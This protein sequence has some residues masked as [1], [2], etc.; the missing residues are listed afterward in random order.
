MYLICSYDAAELLFQQITSINAYVN[1]ESSTGGHP[2][3]Y[4]G[5]P[6]NQWEHDRLQLFGLGAMR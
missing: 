5:A 4:N 3:F 6:R 2:I 1:A